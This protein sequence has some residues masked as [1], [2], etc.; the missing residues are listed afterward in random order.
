MVE[1]ESVDVRNET[2]VIKI[3]MKMNCDRG[4]TIEPYNF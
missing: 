4:V 3:S 1:N 2:E